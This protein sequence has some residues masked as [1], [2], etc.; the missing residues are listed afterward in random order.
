MLRG[1]EDEVGEGPPVEVI[2]VEVAVQAGAAVE[3]E[4]NVQTL[5]P[6]S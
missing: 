1:L 4:R 3:L 6:K 2:Q 5:M